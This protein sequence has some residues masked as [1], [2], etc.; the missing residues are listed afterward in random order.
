M[1]K[2]IHLHTNIEKQFNNFFFI[3]IIIK[4]IVKKVNRL[5]KLCFK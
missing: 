3:I 2:I 5:Q 1:A 4:F